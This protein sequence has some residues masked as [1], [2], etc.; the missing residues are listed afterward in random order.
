ME[1]NCVFS[2]VQIT[3]YKEFR[4]QHHKP[5]FLCT[6]YRVKPFKAECNTTRLN[7]KTDSNSPPP[8]TQFTQRVSCD[9]QNKQRLFPPTATS[10]INRLL[11]FVIET[12]YFFCEVETEFGIVTEENFRLKMIK[13][14]F[15]WNSSLV[16]WRT[17]IG[18]CR[19]EFRSSCQMQGKTQNCKFMTFSFCNV[20]LIW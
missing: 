19:G 7:I 2:E 3:I 15:V 12:H 1:T 11:T 17:Y 13:L 20:C 5:V 14:W 10:N 8:N 4:W 6:T 9:Y 16:L 18:F